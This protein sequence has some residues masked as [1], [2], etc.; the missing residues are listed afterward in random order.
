MPHLKGS[1]VTVFGSNAPKEGEADYE[2]ARALGRELAQSG[3]VVATGG[4]FGTMEATSRGAKEAGGHVIGVTAAVFDG[5]VF[6]MMPKIE[7]SIYARSVEAEALSNA[8]VKQL[9]ATSAS[10]EVYHRGLV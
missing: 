10:S 1:I 9:A 8:I 5:W 6:G 2:Q 3:Y 4:Y 7:G